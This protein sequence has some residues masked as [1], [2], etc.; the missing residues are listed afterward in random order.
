MP[1]VTL[2]PLARIDIDE[3]WEY[4]AEDSETQA[5]VFVDRL[6]AQFKLLALSP[7]MGRSRNEL[8]DNLRS[9]PFER[10]LI[11]YFPIDDGVDIVRVLHNARDIDT[12]L[13][14]AK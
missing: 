3:I 4:I 6:N 1:I 12:I 2:R 11:F 5:D 13:V 10:Y 8:L 7:S 9:F 14:R